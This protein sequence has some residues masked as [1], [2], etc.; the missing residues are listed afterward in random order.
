MAIA[1]MEMG[2]YS[3][4]LLW[5]SRPL[6]LPQIDHGSYGSTLSEDVNRQ[7]AARML[8]TMGLS[9][10]ALA[11]QLRVGVQVAQLAV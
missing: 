2:F 7:F 8:P 6:G 1:K 4:V 3:N 5:D 11:G 9:H 10:L